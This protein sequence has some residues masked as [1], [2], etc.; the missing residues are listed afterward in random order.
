M[1]ASPAAPRDAWP[2]HAGPAARCLRES[3][4][5]TGLGPLPAWPPALRNALT[6]CLDQGFPAFVW[7]GDDLLQF[8]N[9]AAIDM[10]GSRHP[11]AFGRPAREVWHD[12]WREVGPLVDEVLRGGRAVTRNDL[13]LPL[14]RGDDVRPAWFTFCLAPLRDE[15]GPPRGIGIVS[16]ETT[17]QMLTREALR[18]TEERLH[19]AL[20]AGRMA[21][22]DWDPVIDRITASPAHHLLFGLSSEQE[23]ATSAHGYALVHPDDREAHRARVEAAMRAGGPWH[24]EFRIV[25]PCDGQIAWLE[26]RAVVTH[27]DATGKTGMAGVVWDITE[28]K[29]R[30]AA[31]RDEHAR[32]DLLLRLDER[33]RALGAGAADEIAHVATS[34]L[35]PFLGAIRAG[36]AEDAGDGEGLVAKRSYAN[37]VAGGEIRLRQADLGA[38]HLQALRAG[39]TIACAV[40]A[41]DPA[42]T[43]EERARHAALGT[44][45]L[46]HVPLLKAGRTVAVLFVHHRAPRRWTEDELALVNAFAERIRSAVE[47]ATAEAAAHEREARLRLFADVVPDMLWTSDAQGRV[48]WCNERLLEY[49]GDTYAVGDD[50]SAR[51]HPDDL[52]ESRAGWVRAL[53]AG[54]PAS[55]EHRLRGRSAEYRWHLVR[56]APLRDPE[57]RIV[58]W[59]GAMTDIHEERGARELLEARV[60]ARTSELE[61][62]AELRRQ[63][64]ARLEQVQDD[65]RRRIARE[66][67]DALGQQLTAVTIALSHAAAAGDA[68][69]VRERLARVGALLN[70]VDMDLDRL[71]FQLRPTGLEDCGLAEGVAAHA[72]TWSELTGVRVDLLSH[73]LEGRRLPQPVEAAVFRVVQEALTNVAKHAQAHQVG[74]TLEVARGALRATIEDDGRGFAAEGDGAPTSWGLI[75]MKERIKALGGRFAIESTPGAGTTVLVQVPI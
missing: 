7:W 50:W 60:K 12:V 28:R 71:V 2:F 18:R 37:G 16:V 33:L 48:D 26:E 40:V 46:I 8:Y 58:Q 65:E 54:E 25:R 10:I 32:R 39:R 51:V 72:A 47:R 57:G 20:A 44:G 59:I 24:S 63:L 23:F 68:A 70:E 35:G 14:D 55:T 31:Q 27:D 43:A 22:W 53:Q 66:L 1:T 64:N 17:A 19:L 9:D 11:T 36:Y 5:A 75:G 21:T 6:A 74:L 41:N 15:D 30:E 45:A 61:H 52:D 4:A 42:L 69:T 67:H 73:G 56:A 3:A 29:T 38:E 62:A 13:P 34:M 49:F